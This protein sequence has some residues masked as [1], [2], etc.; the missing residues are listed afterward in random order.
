M[1]YAIKFVTALPLVSCTRPDTLIAGFKVK[2]RFVVVS[3]ISCMT[4]SFRSKW[5]ASR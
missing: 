1:T 2:S 3:S 4:A 5:R